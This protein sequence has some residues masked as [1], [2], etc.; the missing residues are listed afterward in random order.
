MARGAVTARA[1]CSAMATPRYIPFSVEAAGRRWAGDWHLDGKDVV[2]GSAYG[3]A[4]AAAGRGKP[5]TVAARLL[6]E[7]IEGA[8][9]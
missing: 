8:M 7:I 9:K 5:E 2:I 1:R 3:S 6:A 4:R